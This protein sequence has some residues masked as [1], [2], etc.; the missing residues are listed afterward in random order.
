MKREVIIILAEDDIGHTNLIM[1]YLIK[2]GITNKI[3]NFLDGQE[4]LDYLQKNKDV[5]GVSYILLLDI[6]MPMVDGM[7]VL[8]KLKQD[9]ELKEIPVI[10]I[11]TEDDQELIEECYALGCVEYIIKSIKDGEFTETIKQLGRTLSKKVIPNIAG[12][13]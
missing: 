9:D 5:H 2:A 11:S 13:V 8:K 7:E 3:L 4:T 12:E 10:V 1:K 6:R